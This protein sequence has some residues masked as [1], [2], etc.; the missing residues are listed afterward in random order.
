MLHQGL[1]VVVTI[2]TRN[3]KP[4]SATFVLLRRDSNVRFPDRRSISPDMLDR[5]TN[6]DFEYERMASE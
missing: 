3:R 1:G 2:V 4:G 6:I 5:K